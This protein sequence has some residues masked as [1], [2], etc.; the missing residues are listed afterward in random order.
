MSDKNGKREATT[1]SLEIILNAFLYNIKNII[2]MLYLKKDLLKFMIICSFAV[3]FF[4]CSNIPEENLLVQEKIPVSLSA[5]V[6]PAHTRVIDSHFEKGDAIGLYIMVQSS[7][8]E[9]FCYANNVKFIYS[10]SGEF[11]SE[12]PLFYPEEGEICDFLAY[13]PYDD[14]KV[15]ETT[16]I[17]VIVQANQSDIKAFS[18][19]DF[20]VA[21]NSGILASKEP[22]HLVFHHKLSYLNIRLRPEEGGYTTE[23]LLTADPIIRIS[24]MYTNA[25]YNFSSGQFSNYN[26]P[27]DI[28]PNGTW[29]IDNNNMLVG[30]SAIIIPQAISASH[31]LIELEIGGVFFDCKLDRDLSFES[32]SPNNFI[33]TVFPNRGGFQVDVSTT[34]IYN[35]EEVQEIDIK[36][37]DVPSYISISEL[38][39]SES[40]IYHV[41]AGD[42]SFV[43]EICR[44]YLLADN[45]NS[46]AVVVY[47]VTGGKIDSTN[48]FVALVEGSEDVSVHGGRVSWDEDGHLTYTAG[49]LARINYV[50]VTSKSKIV[51]F[52]DENVLQLKT[53]PYVLTDTRQTE[54]CV[55]PIVK[56]GYQYWTAENLRASKYTDGVDILLAKN[57]RDS[58][59]NLYC[60]QEDSFFYNRKTVNTGMLPPFDWKIADDDAWDVLKAY[61]GGD[62]SVL[63]SESGWKNS[64]YQGSNLTGFHAT[65]S[66]LY[67]DIYKNKGEYAI[68]WSMSN[69]IS[70]GVSKSVTIGYNTNSL[71]NGLSTGL[72]GLSVRCVKL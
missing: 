20:L 68:F 8:S 19:S 22:V 47:P 30:K 41:T 58:L 39:F 4:S 2:I 12:K 9:Y 56:I 59:L 7:S 52:R 63:K 40:S 37:I 11:V 16:D 72:L 1:I 42:G 55:Y 36:S 24:G 70:N 69:S 13:Y 60:I 3:Y 45:I 25:L 57:S 5:D 48:G 46:R 61:L 28:I 18:T 10:A 26:I 15:L 54:T 51:T 44:E 35:W 31:V 32:E 23:E 67:N 49:I 17:K 65:A 29:K 64:N 50:Y 71:D 38:T 21:K 6:Y 66:G 14:N 62:I 27:V 34:D 53:Y 43:G 33:L